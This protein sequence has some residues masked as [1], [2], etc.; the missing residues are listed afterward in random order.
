MQTSD[1]AIYAIG[2]IAEHRSRL[3]GITLA[4]E[5]QAVVAARHLAGDPL[6]IY[7]GTVGVNI[8]KFAGLT[9]CSIGLPEIPPREKGYEE[10][11]LLDRA[12][13]YYK[14]CIV[15]DDRLVGAILMGGREE[16]QEFRDLIAQGTELSERRHELL[17]GGPGREA[18]EGKLVCSCL[19]I[20]EVNLAR[21]IAAGCHDL[22]SLMSETGAGTGCGSCRGELRRL[23]EIQL[24]AVAV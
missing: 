23:I 9:L 19:Q 15:R 7:E 1:P 2:E 21:R 20:G 22:D 3:H 14:K 8:L 4:A 17:R 13:R 6:A 18:V 16:F 5:E 24:P 12:E 11:V 10:I